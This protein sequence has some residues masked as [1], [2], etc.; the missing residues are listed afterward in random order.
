MLPTFQSWTVR[1]MI[2]CLTQGLLSSHWNI[3]HSTTA[4]FF[5][6]TCMR[7]VRQTLF[8]VTLGRGQGR[9]WG[10]LPSPQRITGPGPTINRMAHC[11]L[12]VIKYAVHIRS[13]LSTDRLTVLININY[14]KKDTCPR[15]ALHHPHWKIVYLFATI[16]IRSSA[17]A[18]RT[19]RP[20]Q[21]Y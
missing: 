20:L 14:A 3:Y 6:P 8:H 2:E 15:W 18:K 12:A 7:W 16:S 17:N 11:Y 5:E 13:R 4:Y 1:K 19:A 21:K 10:Q 9:G